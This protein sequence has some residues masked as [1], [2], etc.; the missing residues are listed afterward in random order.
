MFCACV[1]QSEHDKTILEKEAIEAE[2]EK[3]KQE[4]DEIKFGAPTL[5][6]DGKKFYDAKEFTQARQK[7]QMLLDKHPDLPQSIEAK[8]YLSIIDEEELWNNVINSDNITVSES[9]IDKYPTGKYLSQ[10]KAK[11]VE[12][13]ALNMQKAYD[14]ASSQ[15]S[16]YSWKSFLNEYPDHI[17]ASVIKKRII[18]L[19]VDEISGERETGKMPSFNQYSS[20]YSS[21]STVWITN[22]TGCELTVR[23]SG[24]DIEMIIIPEGGERSMSLSSGIYKIAASACGSNYAGSESLQ[25]EYGSTFYI[26][27][28]RY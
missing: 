25:G 4:L 12:L 5:L 3:V 13:K 17:E 16:S 24:P 7:F 14:F 27:S 23:Y 18:S 10:S 19:E 1:S 21:S 26:S 2:K 28:T 6:V 22:N 11:R 15:N 20:E 9:Y 8:K